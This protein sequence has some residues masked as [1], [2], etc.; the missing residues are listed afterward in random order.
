M[1]ICRNLVTLA[2]VP[3][4]WAAAD[5]PRFRGPNGDGVA[6]TAGLPTEFGPERNAIWKTT[7]PPGFSSPVLTGDRIFLTAANS[8]KLLVLCIN[9][10]TGKIEWQREAPRPRTMT[11][12]APPDVGK[13][14]AAS[15]TP[16]ADGENVYVFF[17][18]FGLI[19]Y[20][21]DGQERWRVPLGP[22]NAPYGMASSPILADGRLLQ[23]CDQDTNSYLLAVDARDGHTLWKAERPE[24]THGF[25]TPAI[26]RPVK[27]PAQVIVSGSYQVVGYSLD[28]GE[29][30]WWVR[31]MAWQAKSVPIVDGDRL[32]VH[33]WMSSGSELGL[34]KQP[35]F[36][37]MLKE[38]DTNHD[39]KLSKDEVPDDMLKKLWFLFDLDQDGYLNDREWNNLRSRDEAGNALFAIRLGGTGDITG[40]VLWKFEKSLPNIPS[41]VLYKGVLY[42]LR[43][44]GVMTT[45]DPANGKVLKQGRIEG[46]LDA[47]YSSPVAAGDKIYTLSNDGKMGVLEAGRDWKVIA[48]NDLKDECWATPAIA[49]GRIY[50]RTNGALYCFGK[51]G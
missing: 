39:G 22:F 18:D 28:T 51:R 27:G 17:E 33:S 11:K 16:V 10:S 34:Q 2:L 31:G 43:E 19:S 37:Q 5:W 47:Y 6:E 48:V 4:V 14:A 3:L 29:K 30:L 41:P 49:D 9:R 40:D 46:A 26:Y 13:K 36:E 35:P 24:A 38:H 44:G 12:N 45:L 1:R 50:V 7:L 15:A 20:R 21:A 42:V 32:Y 23:L 8:G 25:S